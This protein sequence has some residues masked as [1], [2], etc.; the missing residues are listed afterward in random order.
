MLNITSLALEH[1]LEGLQS[2]LTTRNYV[3]H[4][5]YLNTNPVAALVV[6]VWEYFV[7]FLSST[8]RSWFMFL[9]VGGWSMLATVNAVLMLRGILTYVNR[10]QSKKI[11]L[12]LLSLLLM[13]LCLAVTCHFFTFEYAT[14]NAICDAY[15]DAE[16]DAQE[17]PIQVLYF[18]ASVVIAQT[19]VW[20]LTLQ[21]RKLNLGCVPVIQRVLRDGAWAWILIC[22]VFISTI[23]Y[24]LIQQVARAHVNFILQISFFSIVA[25][26]MIMNLQRLKF[27]VDSDEGRVLT[28]NIFMEIP[29]AKTPIED[30]M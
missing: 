19:V 9:L 22:S 18:T 15:C 27:H 17:M 4:I 20:S 8:C 28:T 7:T 5:V 2:S 3:S 24:S 26:R 16:C 25:C 1:N 13:E 29:S 30:D 10:C 14:F 6:L 23:P 21:K 11:G 12:L